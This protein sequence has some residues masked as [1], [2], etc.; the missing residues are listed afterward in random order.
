MTTSYKT[1]SVNGCSQDKEMESVC[2]IASHTVD[3]KECLSWAVE[4]TSYV[5]NFLCEHRDL[6]S[7]FENMH[8]ARHHNIHL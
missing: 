1:T 5:K 7:Y 3:T 8:E 2:Q 6:S 4:I